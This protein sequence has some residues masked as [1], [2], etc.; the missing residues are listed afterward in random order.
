MKKQTIRLCSQSPSRALILSNAGV[1]FI[2]SP[3]EFDDIPRKKILL[4]GGF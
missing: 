2:Q 4:E 1:D 3:V